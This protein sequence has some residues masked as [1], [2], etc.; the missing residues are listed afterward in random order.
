M[1]KCS[2]L[3][4]TLF[5]SVAG[6]WLDLFW[7]C[8]LRSKFQLPPNLLQYR[9][10]DDPRST[11]SF[12]AQDASPS[13]PPLCRS[14]PLT[15]L[16]LPVRVTL[17]MEVTD[18]K[19]KLDVSDA[20]QS[21][22]AKKVL[23]VLSTDGPLTQQDVVYYKKEAIWRQMKFYRLQAQEVKLELQRYKRRFQAFVASYLLLES[24]YA[25]VLELLGEDAPQQLDLTNVSAQDVKELLE[26]RRQLLV[27]FLKKKGTASTDETVSVLLDGVRLQAEKLE[28]HTLRTA[29]EEKL[30][31][32]EAQVSELQMA[33]DRSE[34]ASI[35][36]VHANNQ[37]KTDEPEP[38][39][40]EPPAGKASPG[41]KIASDPIGEQATADRQELE[42]LQVEFS[43]MKA[44][45][46]SLT[47]SLKA[48]NS[49]LATCEQTNME[50]SQK[51]FN[52]DE[53]ELMKSAKY[54]SILSLNKTLGETNAQLLK[55]KDDLVARI[56]ALEK[57]QGLVMSLV[58]T[59]ITEK[60]LH[61]KELL[62]KAETDLA[63]VRAVR[64]E[65][66]GKQA[67]LKLELEQGKSS[68]QAV[69]LSETL[70]GRLL[71][72]EQTL[73]A[74]FSVEAEAALEALDKPEL[75][76][77][78]QILSGELRDIESAFQET[79]GLALD[80][81]KDISENEALVKKIAVEKNKADQKYFASMRVKD[82]LVAENKILKSQIAKSQEL[83]QKHGEIEKTYVAKIEVLNK[84]MAELRA[85]KES[86]IRETSKLYESLKNL[87][88]SREGAAKEVAQLKE[89]LR[90]ISKEKEVLVEELSDVKYT[91][92]K[93]Q[94]KLRATESLLQ[95]YKMN[96]TSSIQ[97]EDE[98]QLEALRSIT[99]CSV[100]SKNWKN[101]AITTCGHVFCDS[102]VQERLN[103]R[104]RRC[105]T[106]NK[107]FSSNDLLVVHL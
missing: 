16:F 22:Q 95:K 79:R 6:I 84:S 1:S 5:T 10:G 48:A 35:K 56:S 102:C 38:L 88:R 18:R 60:N 100:C 51:L 75:V 17:T 98:K 47:E 72:L 105:P 53:L 89:E 59:E 8:T 70:N 24:W 69:A 86:S 3:S 20:G 99:K 23:Q 33:R 96:N 32:L 66:I 83:I 40:N 11:T 93:L 90:R 58:S 49:K 76:K 87:T 36:R 29:L 27:E 54:V 74:E 43:L 26:Q 39:P 81:L 52:L 55:L 46:G 67:V 71:K 78:L 106:C 50:L 9:T 28:A 25:T 21:P 4:R 19:R 91:Q 62:L 68:I 34:S 15:P 73:S 92:N 77:R 63:R 57:N 82:L 7:L 104:L 12:P 97:Q 30:V 61:L 37:Q 14:V 44:G 41:D 31:V 101:T 107:G 94:G 2:S 80:K 13:A 45:L 65:L 103:A 85:I 42:E 64:D